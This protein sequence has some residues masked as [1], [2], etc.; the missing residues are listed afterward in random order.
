MNQFQEA[1]PYNCFLEPPLSRALIRFTVQCMLR[2]VRHS[3]KIGVSRIGFH[4]DPNVTLASRHSL[5]K[6]YMRYGYRMLRS[7]T[8]VKRKATS[9]AGAYLVWSV[10][11]AMRSHLRGTHKKK[12]RLQAR[13]MIDGCVPD[14]W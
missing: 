13:G 12:G 3:W 10:R 4:G 14:T 8:H 2:P 7:S 11:F 9:K 1:A 6:A 5:K